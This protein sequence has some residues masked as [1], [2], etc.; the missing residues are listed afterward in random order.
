M[1]FSL[2]WKGIKLSLEDLGTGFA[3][4]GMKVTLI[5]LV[6]LFMFLALGSAFAI[7]LTKDPS[8]LPSQLIDKPFPE[9]SLPDLFDEEHM[10]TK[11]DMSGQVTLVNIFGSWCMACD[12]EHE[13]LMSIAKNKELPILGVDWRDTRVKGKRWLKKRGNPYTNVVFDEFSKF[14]IDLGITGAP[15]SFIVDKR[16]QIRYKHIGPITRK[17]WDEI[18]KPIVVD[19]QAEKLGAE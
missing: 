8:I 5:G 9:F 19:L 6:P 13:M 3:M 16:G 7:S 4:S 18:L 1:K 15:E 10:L 14:A 11:A 12:Y 2:E 17:N